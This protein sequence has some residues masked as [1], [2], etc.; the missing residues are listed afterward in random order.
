MSRE[1][2]ITPNGWPCT[3]EQCPPGHFVHDGMLCFKT[4]YKTNEGKIEAYCSSGEFFV[5]G[6]A[7]EPCRKT[8]QV[9]PVTSSW[10]L[11]F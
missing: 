6:C 1:L 11:E 4:E 8:V 10:H 9:Q 2:I 7:D 5:G 3:L